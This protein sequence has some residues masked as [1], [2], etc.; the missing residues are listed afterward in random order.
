M[1]KVF[2][3]AAFL[4]AMG[5]MT[6][7]FTSCGEEDGTEDGPTLEE[8]INFN[9]L[10]VVAQKNGQVLIDGKV[11]A[12]AKIKSLVL[13]TDEDGKNVVIDLLKSGDQTKAK[14]IDE[15]GN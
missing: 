15:E 1:K 13:S 8:K 2:K 9:G 12:T 4:L 14:A 6:S 3:T 5:L 11:T 10:N 7:T